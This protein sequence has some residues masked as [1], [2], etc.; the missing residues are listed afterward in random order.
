[1]AAST[2][3][4]SARNRLAVALISSVV[5]WSMRANICDEDEVLCVCV[6]RVETKCCVNLV[7]ERER[8]G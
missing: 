3:S 6:V 8:N 1:M 4:S 7:F 2:W 5:S